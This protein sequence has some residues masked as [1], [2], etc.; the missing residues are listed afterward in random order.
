MSKTKNLLIGML[1]TLALIASVLCGTLFVSADDTAGTIT[2]S[3]FTQMGTG[4]TASPAAGDDTSTS[5]TLAYGTDSHLV[6]GDE[7]GAF[8]VD[9]GTFK[10]TITIDQLAVGQAFAVSFIKDTSAK[11]FEGAVGFSYVYEKYN[12]DALISYIV[13]ASNGKYIAENAASTSPWAYMKDGNFASQVPDLPDEPGVEEYCQGMVGILSGLSGSNILTITNAI[14]GADFGGTTARPAIVN[15]ASLGTTVD[16]NVFSARGL[17]KANMVLVISACSGIVNKMDAESTP[18]TDIQLTVGTPNE[19]NTNNYLDSSER[20]AIVEDIPGYAEQVDAALAGTLSAE[21]YAELRANVADIDL[22]ALRPRDRYVYQSQYDAFM[23]KLNALDSALENLVAD[24]SAYDAALKALSDLDSVD[25]VA[26]EAAKTAKAEYEENG[27]YIIYLSGEDKTQVEGII[28]ALNEKLLERAEIHLQIKGFEDAVAAFSADP[29]Q[30]TVDQIIA[31]E[32]AK[33]LIDTNGIEQLEEAD[34]TAFQA[35]IA[36]ADEIY[37][38]ARSANPYVVEMAKVDSYNLAIAALADKTDVA[39]FEKVLADRPVMSTAGITD[40]DELKEVEEA[41]A[42]AD[43]AFGEQIARVIGGWL[44]PYEAAVA[45][46]TDLAS[47]TDAKINAAEDAQYSQ[48]DLEKM[49]AVAD[50]IGYNTDA[51]KV[52]LQECDRAVLAAKTRILVMEFNNYVNAEIADNAALQVAYEAY[53]AASEAALDALNEEE[54]TAYNEMFETAADLYNE[55]STAL[56]ESK[57]AAFESVVNAEGFGDTADSVA[58]AKNARADVPSFELLIDET[59]AEELR[60]RYDAAVAKLTDADLYYVYSGG[61]SWTISSTETGIQMALDLQ[62]TENNQCEGL[63]IVEDPLNIDG[64]DFAFE[65]TQPGKLWD[66][67]SGQIMYVMNIMRSAAT[68]K[69]QAQGFSIYFSPNNV[70]ELEVL[71]YG[72]QNSGASAGENL[73]AQGKVENMQFVVEEGETYVPQTIRVRIEMDQTCYN[74]WINSLQ[75][76]VYYRQ[77]LNTEEGTKT[78]LPEYEVGSEIGDKLF[79]DGKAYVTFIV[80]ANGSFSDEEGQAL[81]TV[82]MIGDKTFGDYVP[83]VYMTEL[84]LISGPTKTEYKKG[85]EFDK[86]GIK[87]QAVMSDGTTIDIDLDDIQVLG[88]NSTSKGEKNVTLRYTDESGVTLSKVIKVTVVDD[89]DSGTEPG[90]DEPGT[91]CGGSIGAVAVGMGIAVLAMAAGCVLVIRKK[92]NN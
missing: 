33:L 81:L 66:G 43:A 69:D 31:A 75:L 79:V 70:N 4:V 37:E 92:N 68:Y 88:F 20:A 1:L 65:F 59:A 39:S 54:K 62:G 57:V 85:E 90:G 56:F 47:L 60:S 11:P 10:L 30:A 17:D 73:L 25:S 18:K 67:Q 26:L 23:E 50:G 87:M 34:K 45:E 91:G 84:N 55:K 52:R 89:G 71:I 41:Y 6:Y 46:L 40:E 28:A 13:D 24:V 9:A 27:K 80:F 21:D 3:D 76:S 16:G 72:A 32:N 12:D 14:D 42:A 38:Q 77:I 44:T 22:S 15:G 63:A 74:I 8:L 58:A 61:T 29:T 48:I 83:P 36:A 7:N 78:N 2:G 51:L 82:R 49:L 64:F 35:R 86:A 53:V 5:V 19:K